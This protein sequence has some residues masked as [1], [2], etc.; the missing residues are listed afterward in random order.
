ML[1]PTGQKKTFVNPKVGSKFTGKP[2]R[3]ESVGCYS[4]AVVVEVGGRG[5]YVGEGK[6]RMEP[7]DDLAG[8]FLVQ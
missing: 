6:W 8:G 3:V 2:L 1:N 5:C 7:G 4:D